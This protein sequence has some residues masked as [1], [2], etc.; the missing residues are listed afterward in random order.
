MLRNSVSRRPLIFITLGLLI[1]AA[2]IVGL[3]SKTALADEGVS[4]R[5][6]FTVAI[7]FIQDPT[8]CGVGDKCVA[9]VTNFPPRFYIDAEGIGDTSRLGTMFLKIQKC[10]DPAASPFGSYDGTFTL[11]APNGKDSL[12]G[13]YTGKNTN[14]GDAYGFNTFSGDLK[15]TGGTGRFDDAQGHA[16]FTAVAHGSSA[17]AFYAVEGFVSSRTN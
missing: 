15:I 1:M 14:A 13:I 6:N 12:I 11:T 8:T 2:V 10:L 4:I 7:S 9:C 5:G 17:T 16:H 3:S